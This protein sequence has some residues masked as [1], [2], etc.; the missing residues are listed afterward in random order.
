MQGKEV[1]VIPVRLCSA[2]LLALLPLLPAC[3]GDD[4]D[5][6]AN[7]VAIV[8]YPGETVDAVLEIE[9]DETEAAD[10]VLACSFASVCGI[11]RSS[12]QATVELVGVSGEEECAAQIAVTAFPWAAPGPY[13][14]CVRFFYTYTDFFGW[15]FQDDTRG[16]IEVT[17]AEEPVPIFTPTA[18]PTPLASSPRRSAEEQ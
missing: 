5:D 9:I 2:L 17:V 1:S 14:I 11:D 18:T 7:R 8:L 16:Y 4:D 10:F 3:E 15:L 6:F 13:R 12:L